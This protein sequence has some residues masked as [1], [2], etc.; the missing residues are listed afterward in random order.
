MN[1]AERSD[2]QLR[3]TADGNAWMNISN[4]D[5]HRRWLDTP[6]PELEQT[7]RYYGRSLTPATIEAVLRAAEFG[8]MR[9]LT[10][11]TYETLAIDPHFTGVTRKRLRSVLTCQ[12]EV[13]PAKGEGID[14]ELAQQYA[15]VVRQQLAWVPRFKQTLLQ[16]NWGH[17]HGRAAAEKIWRENPPGSKV[18]WR[19]E[20]VN[21]IHPRRL[22]FGPEREL[23]VRDDPFSG[24]GFE[25]RGLDL[26]QHP[27]KFFTFLPQQF[28]DYPERE[29]FGPRGLYWAFFK[30]FGKREQ[31]VLLEVFGK[32]WRIV[33]ADDPSKIQPDSLEQAKQAAD[34]MGAN[35]TGGMPPG[36]KAQ[37]DQPGQGA[38]QVH[39]DVIA[40]SNDEISK[41]VLGEVR[42]TDSKP[43]ALGSASD[44]IAQEISDVVKEE[45]TANLTDL[46]T[47][48]FAA[49]IIVLN[50]GPEALPYCPTIKIEY[51]APVDKDKETDRAGKVLSFGIPI[52]E[53]ELYERTGFTKPAPGDAIIQ[54]SPS[55]P[56]A[57][58]GM[59]P[60]P[61]GSS[62]G[63]MPG[64]E[65]DAG[66]GAK[67]TGDGGAALPDDGAELGGAHGDPLAVRRAVTMLAL[68][69]QLSNSSSR[70]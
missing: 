16:L 7:R 65:N 27:F 29:G 26:R 13:V 39:R 25:A 12:P 64:E 31:L 38:G 24:F 66:G 18:R 68:I 46:L 48:Q 41:L 58:P 11:L 3:Y 35:A 59:P 49:D 56:S 51:K 47:E 53:D 15:D 52:K 37:T 60:T 5:L 23:R 10:D 6:S 44:A 69:S 57:I 62:R 20:G 61:G 28:N 34:A 2:L 22:C 50:F 8:H 33:F 42:T 1:A 30:R 54:Q 19:I 4:V 32:P 21:W 14:P 43:A 40:D 55:T 63:V 9:D 45:D 70:G 36:W 67:P 17:C